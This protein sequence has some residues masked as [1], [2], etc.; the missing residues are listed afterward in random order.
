MVLLVFAAVIATALYT[1]WDPHR[2]TEAT[3][4]QLDKRVEYGAYLFAQNCIVCHGNSGEGGAKSNRLKV[5]P[6]LNRPDL[7]GVDPKTNKASTQLRAQAFKLVVNTITCGRVGK[8]MPTWGQSQGGSLNDEQIQQLATMI[9]QGTGWD[10]TDEF[11]VRGLEQ[12]HLHGYDADG[13][14]LAEALDASSTTVRLNSVEG[15]DKGLRLQ[16]A[17]E[18]MLI[19]DFVPQHLI[20]TRGA[21][22]T[23]AAAHE[24]AKEVSGDGIKNSTLS[25]PLDGASTEAFVSGVSQFSSGMTIRVENEVMTVEEVPAARITVERGLGTT[26]PAPHAADAQVLKPPVPPDPPVIVQAACGQTAPAAVPTA[27]GPTTAATE[28]T[29]IGQGTAFDKTEL[30]GVAGT[31]L[32]IT[33]DNRD[34]GINHNIHFFKG[35]DASG[36]E[37]AASDIAPGPVVQTLKLDPLDAG[38]YFY[39][40][41]VHPGQMEGKLTTVAAGAGAAPGAVSTPAATTEAGAVASPT[42]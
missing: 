42:P 33:F 26:S 19:T 17:D 12:Y 28:L 24:R 39:Q 15:L 31:A 4:R 8:A 41:D 27:A 6:A 37:V 2:A 22:G 40:C 9:T 1:I 32:T 16:I 25:K 35:A 21:N 34:A 30:L 23:S 3:D 5:A 10:L 20:V 13:F 11:A 29:V 14:R 36:D 7:Q 38:D 18:L